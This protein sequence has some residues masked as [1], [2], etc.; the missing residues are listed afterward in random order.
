MVLRKPDMLYVHSISFTP[1]GI[2]K[3]ISIVNTHTQSRAHAHVHYC[4]YSV[5][6]VSQERW[7]CF[8]QFY[9]NTYTHVLSI[10]NSNTGNKVWADVI[11][12]HKFAPLDERLVQLM[13][14][15][16]KIHMQKKAWGG[17]K[18]CSVCVCVCCRCCKMASN[19]M[20]DSSPNSI[21]SMLVMVTATWWGWSCIVLIIIPSLGEG[22]IF[23]TR[24]Y[25]SSE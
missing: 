3:C 20:W 11:I 12:V 18:R 25:K 16:E 24:G 15:K 6:L 22:D 23:A 2:S 13:L 14:G 21:S 1:T 9:T 10:F 4:H 17:K 19:S 8:L 5:V 7:W